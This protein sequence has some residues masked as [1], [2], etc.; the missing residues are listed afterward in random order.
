MASADTVWRKWSS[1]EPSP[2]N[3]YESQETYKSSFKFHPF[4]PSIKPLSK[5]E[6][7]ASHVSGD[8]GFH[9]GQVNGTLYTDV[10]D[11][12]NED[13]YRMDDEYSIDEPRPQTVVGNHESKQLMN[14]NNQDGFTVQELMNSGNGFTYD[15]FI[16]LPGFTNFPVDEVTLESRLTKNIT[17]KTPF[18]SSPI[19]TV[20]ESEMAIGMALLGGIGVIHHNCTIERQAGEVSKVKRFKQGFI[21]NPI[22]LSVEATL[23]NARNVQK[24]Y[25]VSGILITDNGCVGGILK[26]IVTG[27]DLDYSGDCPNNK[28]ICDVMTPLVDL[29]VADSSVT[30]KEAN[31]VL[32]RSKK[33]KL[34]IV[35]GEGRLVALISRT[36]L[37]KSDKFPLASKDGRNLLLVGAAITP[38]EC[39]IPRLKAL[40]N[41]GVDVIVLNSPQG[42]STQ[43]IERIK[44]IKREY[45]RLEVI[46]GN[47]VTVAQAENLIA[48]EADALRVGSVCPK[49]ELS[50]VGRP[51]ATAV[52][53]VS[54]Y[55]NDYNV[56]CIA[57]GGIENLSHIVK[58]LSLGASTVMLNTLLSGTD[59]SPGE[60]Y[61]QDGV[62]GK[63]SLSDHSYT[64]AQ[65]IPSARNMSE[66]FK[67]KGSIHKF[68]P[69]IIS[70]VRHACQSIGVRD[71]SEL[72]SKAQDGDVKFDRQS[73]NAQRE[74][75]NT[76]GIQTNK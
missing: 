71:L 32:M 68:V 55:A 28:Q 10:F 5:S 27:R 8:F 41:A 40:V 50:A 47:V 61:Y 26:G 22:V 67:D 46:A 35:D 74:C 76:T 21:T 60:Y 18:V 38:D 7:D 25:E 44:E 58:A 23:E 29:V 73:V 72:R 31:G 65:N 75:R 52:F 63:K 59:E 64:K 15:D 30:L 12:E 43:Q 49:E 36:D 24:Q 17:L 34:P 13:N 33:G 45:P 19:D 57:D 39:D 62:R 20:T 66:P 14:V 56:P 1:P 37:K 70:G 4:N 69:Y 6:S 16:I 53:K 11:A 54:K 2:N 9:N 48:A 51:Q 3:S 42:N